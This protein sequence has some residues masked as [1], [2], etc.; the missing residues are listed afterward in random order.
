[1]E[2]QSSWLIWSQILK[3]VH[4]RAGADSFHS[5][6]DL[7]RTVGLSLESFLKTFRKPFECRLEAFENFWKP[8]ESL[9]RGTHIS[10]ALAKSM[11]NV[12]ETIEQHMEVLRITVQIHH[13]WAIWS[14]TSQTVCLR[15]GA[16]SF[17][18]LIAASQNYLS[19]AW[20]AESFWKALRKPFECRVDVFFKTI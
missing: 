9:P 16:D 4:V 3:T 6:L 17:H 11:Q 14:R 19:F 12:E 20:K 1:M 15:A 2:T 13:S 10:R 5:F 7:A 8:F 18:F